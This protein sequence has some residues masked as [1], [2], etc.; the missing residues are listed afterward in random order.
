MGGPPGPSDFLDFGVS[1]SVGIRGTDPAAA[2]TPA[3]STTTT[4]GSTRR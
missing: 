4:D 3:V 2:D 1:I